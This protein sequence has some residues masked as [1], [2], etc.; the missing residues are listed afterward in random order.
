MHSFCTLFDSNYLVKGLAMYNSLLRTGEPFTLYIFCFDDRTHEILRT[1]NLAHVVL[2]TLEEFETEELKRV[3]QDR[4]R[5]EYCWTCTPH[6]IRFALDTYALPQITYLDADLY[7]FGSPTVLLEEFERSGGSVLITG[8][9]YTPRY[10]QSA[11][12]GTYCVQFIS[13]RADTRGLEVLRWWGARCLEW[14]Y[15][16]FENGMFG[17][18]K[19]L[20]DWPSRFHGVHVLRHLGG[21]V[22]P[23]NVQQYRVDEGPAVNGV[24]VIF[25]HFHHVTWFSDN[26][27]ELGRYEL[28]KE[29][30]THIYL[31]YVAQLEQSLEEVRLLHDDLLPGKIP[32]SRGFLAFLKIV[33]RKLYGEHHVIQR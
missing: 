1:K 6:V 8:H 22:A 13:F 10:D 26:T 25:Y 7:F 9:R 2:I 21:G 17:D 27:F 15:A 19:Y 3:K 33:K 23:W 16:R 28:S 12:S 29:A 4:S 5:G 31:P 24:P 30:I 20:D 11:T 18:Q 32:P 14:C